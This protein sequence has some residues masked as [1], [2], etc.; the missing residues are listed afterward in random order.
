VHARFR[1]QRA[2][3]ALGAIIRRPQR[4]RAD[5]R[6]LLRTV[7]HGALAAARLPW[8]GHRVRRMAAG[9]VSTTCAV[10]AVP[11]P[12]LTRQAAAMPS[13]QRH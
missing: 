6:A 11:L 4:P 8:L 2:V 1:S 9:R 7:T 3:D 5:G 12:L 10:P 13:E